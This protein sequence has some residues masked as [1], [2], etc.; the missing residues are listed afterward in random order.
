MH[1]WKA[2]AGQEKYFRFVI[3]DFSLENK[4]IDSRPKG[5]D[6]E[7]LEKLLQQLP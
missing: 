3:W 1:W 6:F 2:L 5:F 7:G 4:P